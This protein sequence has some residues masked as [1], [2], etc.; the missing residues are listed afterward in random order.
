MASAK[1]YRDLAKD[2]LI[3]AEKTRDA[4]QREALLEMAKA[5]THAALQLEL[6]NI[7][8]GRKAASMEP[9]RTE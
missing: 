7:A 3:W 2:C 6:R 9:D 4:E 5:W 8:Q 1:E